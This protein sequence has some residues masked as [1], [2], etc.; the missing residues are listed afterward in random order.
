MKSEKE[1][2]RDLERQSE[3]YSEEDKQRRILKDRARK[4]KEEKQKAKRGKWMGGDHVVTA[5]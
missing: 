5:L 4:W 2:H 3:W 1:K